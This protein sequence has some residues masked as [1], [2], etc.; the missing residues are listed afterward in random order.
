MFNG[1]VDIGESIFVVGVTMGTGRKIEALLSRVIPG[2]GTSL[3]ADDDKVDLGAI[4]EALKDVDAATCLGSDN[5]LA[6]WRSR[7][8]RDGDGNGNRTERSDL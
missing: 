5:L 2:G 3:M 6:Y 7:R 8:D 1:L 4:G